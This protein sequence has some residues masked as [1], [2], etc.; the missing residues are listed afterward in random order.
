MAAEFVGDR[1][2][3]TDAHVTSAG[4]AR[5]GVASP[6]ECVAVMAEHGF[7]I[8][9]H[10]SHRVIA[11]DIERAD[12]VLGMDY[13]H[14]RNLATL[15]PQRYERIHTLAEFVDR[16]EELPP[17]PSETLD[18]WFAR[19]HAT[20][21]TLPHLGARRRWEVADPG[22]RSTRFQRQVAGR[23]EEL[24]TRVAKQLDQFLVPAS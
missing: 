18:V 21:P 8:S 17:E 15:S 20:R 16:S 11:A 4:F 19:L 5:P 7:D 12:L 13:E 9:E 23:I 6:P 2:R 22:G 10:R 3:G 1:L 14:C 24:S